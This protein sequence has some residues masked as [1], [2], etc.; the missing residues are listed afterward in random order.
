MATFEGRSAVVFGAT[1]GMGAAT[2]RLLAERG[3]H[4]TLVGR[5]RELGQRVADECSGA[6]V[7]C[8]FVQADIGDD[9]QVAAAVSAAVSAYGGVTM[10]ANV[11][12]I[13]IVKPFVD[14]TDDDF[15]SL[16]NTNTRGT[17]HCMKHEITAM[18]AAG[19]GSI[20]NVNSIGSHIAISGNSLYGASKRAVTALT[21]Y[22]AFEYGAAGIRVNQTSP[23]ATR[24]EMLQGWIT[25]AEQSG[26]TMAAFEATAALRRVAEPIEQARVIAFLLSDESSY[27][28]GVDIPVDGGTILLNRGVPTATGAAPPTPGDAHARQG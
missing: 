11:A 8:Q 14:L 12:A 28:T 15:D 1:T 27:V 13:D 5:R 18:L 23:G 7:Q 4:V 19:G 16:F 17:W 22:A 24:T 26:V 3:A 10:A 25:Q 6:G 2:A 21:E 9:S 20:V